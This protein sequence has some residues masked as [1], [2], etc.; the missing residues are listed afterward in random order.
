MNRAIQAVGTVVTSV[1]DLIAQAA[2]LGNPREGRLRLED[3]I[4]SGEATGIEGRE[5][6][7]GYRVT[8]PPDDRY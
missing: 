6:T 4:Q 3:E 8:H 7:F 1:L 5:G 2:E